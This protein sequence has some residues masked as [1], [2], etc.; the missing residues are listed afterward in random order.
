MEFGIILIMLI[1]SAFF[2]GSETAFVVANRLRVEVLARR[3]GLV[4]P[5]VRDFINN[6]SAFLT[7]TLVG[8]NVVNVI[9]S[10][11]MAFYLG[12]PL[13]SFYENVVSLGAGGID[14]AVLVSQT[15][16]ASAIVLIFGEILPK[17]LMREVANHAVFFLAVPLRIAHYVLLPMIKVAALSSSML[18]RLF[19]ADADT[20]AQF[21]RRDFEVIIQ[22]TRAGGDLELDEEESEL[23]S[24]LFAM[25]TIRVKE[26]MAPRTEIEA[27]EESTSVEELR[28]RFIDTG[29][30]KMPVFRDNIDNI[31]GMVFAYDLF[32]NPPSVKD[33]MRAAYFVPE[34]KRSK[35]LLREFLATNTSIAIVIDEYGGTAGL[36]T[37]EDLLEELFGDIQDEFDVE[38]EVL[39]QTGENSFIASGRV[40]LDEMEERFGLELPEGDYETVAGYL[41]ERIGSIPSTQETFHFDRFRFD[42]VKATSNRID[43]V[44]ITRETRDSSE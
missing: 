42:I 12:P 43:L 39:R 23:L 36:V 18:V 9:Y 4:G 21:L 31:V 2:S 35:D 3:E 6:P 19:R 13:R 24:N 5:I 8:N 30:S 14:V 40:R 1:L 22:E 41:L 28:R 10:T 44:R 11:L 33:M 34:S 27:V 20:F 25:N 17:S 29:H 7:T 16:V 15:I 32:E 38:T 37:R 26:S